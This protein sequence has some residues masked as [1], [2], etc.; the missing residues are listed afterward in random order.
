[1]MKV[2]KNIVEWSD[3]ARLVVVGGYGQRKVVLQVGNTLRA[4]PPAWSH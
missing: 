4:Q 3:M 2:F 1:M